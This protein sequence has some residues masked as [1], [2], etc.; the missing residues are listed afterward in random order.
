[1]PSNSKL[2]TMETEN[3]FLYRKVQMSELTKPSFKIPEILPHQRTE[4]SSSAGGQREQKYI[5]MTSLL[6]LT[7][8]DATKTI[9]KSCGMVKDVTEPL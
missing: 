3:N 9:H 8:E 2:K 5:S 1:M 4:F 6:I 7:A